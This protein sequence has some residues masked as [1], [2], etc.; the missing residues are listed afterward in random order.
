MIAGGA[1]VGVIRLMTFPSESSS[2][3]LYLVAIATN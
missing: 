2:H 1:E 3:L